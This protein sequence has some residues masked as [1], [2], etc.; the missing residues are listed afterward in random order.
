MM[1]AVYDCDMDTQRLFFP[2]TTVA[3]R[4]ATAMHQ[5]QT[6]KNV[7]AAEV[8]SR[9]L[10]CYGLKTNAKV[11]TDKYSC[12]RNKRKRV[13]EEKRGLCCVG[14]FTSRSGVRLWWTIKGAP[15]FFAGSNRGLILSIA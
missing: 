10:N 5:S 6:T 4:K 2:S 1:C 9:D 7:C 8:Q 3:I 11:W 12:E 13:K 15:T 14:I